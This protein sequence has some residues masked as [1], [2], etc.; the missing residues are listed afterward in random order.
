MY[1]FIPA[2]LPVCGALANLSGALQDAARAEVSAEDA[3]P[4]DVESKLRCIL[5]AHV[6]G[7]HQALVRELAGAKNGALWTAWS[8]G[9]DPA[10]L[11][12]RSDCPVRRAEEACCSFAHHPGSHS[13]DVTDPWNLPAH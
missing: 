8:D 9:Q 2:L 3:D 7:D 13:Y 4:G 11:T 12:V 6:A 1:A 5:Q 10:E